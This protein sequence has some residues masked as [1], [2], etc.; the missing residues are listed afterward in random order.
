MTC[1]KNNLNWI[2]G[3]FS[4]WI[5]ALQEVGRRT[6]EL[7]NCPREGVVDKNFKIESQGEF[8]ISLFRCCLKFARYQSEFVSSEPCVLCA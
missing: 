8:Y 4:V 6:E 5:V 3:S 7:D 1:Y 2:L